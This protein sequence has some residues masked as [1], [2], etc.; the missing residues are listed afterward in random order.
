MDSKY[1]HWK[2][3][4]CELK[5]DRGEEIVRGNFVGDEVLES[6]VVAIGPGEADLALASGRRWGRCDWSGRGLRGGSWLR[7]GLVLL[8][9][10][11]GGGRFGRGGRAGFAT[12][13]RCAFL[14]S[15]GLVMAKVTGVVWGRFNGESVG[16]GRAERAG[17]DGEGR[18]GNEVEKFD[19]HLES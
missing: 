9:W 11:L 10:G 19:G 7:S 13:R 6:T 12:L 2:R 5:G 15:N 18:E 4:G 17:N 16:G 8:G 1:K 14:E 3:G